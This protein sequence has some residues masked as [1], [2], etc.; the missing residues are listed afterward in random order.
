[1]RQGLTRN[2]VSFMKPFPRGH[3]PPAPD[4][5]CLAGSLASD[6]HCHIWNRYNVMSGYT[7]GNS[8]ESD[9]GASA[10]EQGEAGGPVQQA[11]VEQE[12]TESITG[13]HKGTGPKTDHIPNM[14]K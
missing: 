3:S 7:R 8:A 1:M 9:L 10:F 11:R 5:E 6:T 14:E 13:P 2:V 4:M 12:A